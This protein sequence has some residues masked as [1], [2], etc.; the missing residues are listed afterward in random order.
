MEVG[1]APHMVGNPKQAV[2]I[3]Y[4][5]SSITSFSFLKT[6]VSLLRAHHHAAAPQRTLPFHP[7]LLWSFTF[8]FALLQCCQT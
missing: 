1:Q 7:A 3:S 6:E 2:V 8:I 4:V 5:F